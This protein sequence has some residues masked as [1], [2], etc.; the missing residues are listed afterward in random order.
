MGEISSLA[1]GF[2][3][4]FSFMQAGLVTRLSKKAN[5]LFQTA[6]GSFLFD[7]K[8]NY[9]GAS[10]TIKVGRGC[11]TILA[12]L[13]LNCN[14]KRDINEPKVIGLNIQVDGGR[15]EKSDKDS[16]IRVID[17]T[18]YT[19][20]LVV[21][22]KNSIQSISWQFKK[23]TFSVTAD[24]NQFKLVEI[25]IEVLAEASGTVNIKSKNMTRGLGGMYVRFYRDNQKLTGRTLTEEDGYFSY[26]GLQPGKYVARLDSSQLTKKHLTPTPKLISFT[27]ASSNEG[28]MVDGLNFTLQ[29]TVKDSSE[30]ALTKEVA[31]TVSLKTKTN[32]DTINSLK[33]GNQAEGKSGVEKPDRRNDSIL[34]GVR[35][36]KGVPTKG[37]QIQRNDSILPG[38]RYSKGVPTKSKQI[39]RID[40]ILQGVRYSKGV[41]TKSKQ[42]QKKDSILPVVRYSQGVISKIIQFK[43]NDSILSG[44]RY[45]QGVPSIIIQYKRNDS[46]LPAVRYS[47]GIP[48]TGRPDLSNNQIQKRTSQTTVVKG[49]QYA[50]Q[51][52]AYIVEGNAISVEQKV[53]TITGLSVN[54]VRV[55]GLYKIWIE[56]FTGRR[57]AERFEKRL[58]KMGFKSFVMMVYR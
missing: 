37:K 58:S 40:S 53:K 45:S 30:S 34:P 18:P 44:E 55:D 3:Y 32:M 43:R 48:V 57:Q 46:I 36:S 19:S 22:D 17:L 9:I 15:V 27:V 50:I 4:D 54:I 5:A 33:G 41:P 28:D 39:Q 26:M 6:G 29:S 31:D 56:G 25:P 23:L 51:V 14:G 42:I 16:T 11:F 35:Y 7:R 49:M 8:S 2:R 52:G 38:V 1:V 47:Q 12:F 24:P 10:N 13:D 21:V 20:Y